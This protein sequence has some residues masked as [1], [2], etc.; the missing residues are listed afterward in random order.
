M[1]PTDVERI[2]DALATMLDAVGPAKFELFLAKLELLLAR[3][4]GDAARDV[5]LIDEA[6]THLDASD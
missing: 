3:E 2:Y 6:S 1:T 4:V 5:R